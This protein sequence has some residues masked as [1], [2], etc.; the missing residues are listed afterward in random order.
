MSLVPVPQPA[1]FA[2]LFSDASND[3]HNGD[4]RALLAPFDIDINNPGNNATPDA[5]RQQIAAA[6]N[7]R[8]PLA[9]VLLV[10]GRLKPFFLPF[11]LE[12]AVGATPNPAIDGKIFAYD[13]ELIHNQGILV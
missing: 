2:N 1:L 8:I 7:Q 6:G 10:E 9:M 12:Q 11:R 13:G 4:Y 5:V 3:P